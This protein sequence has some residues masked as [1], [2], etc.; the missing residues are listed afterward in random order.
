[1][2]K[3]ES[4]DAA[5]VARLCKVWDELIQT[6]ERLRSERGAAR[7]ERDQAFRERDQACQERDD[8]QQRVGSLQADLE[9]ATTRRLEAE[10]VSAGLTV[11]LAEVRRNLQ[12]ES[13]ELG[14]LSTVL[15]VVYGDLQVVRSEG[16]SLLM[17]HA[18]EI[19]AYVR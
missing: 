12:A 6:T 2:E 16:T 13:D 15:G 11:D 8:T 9:S 4:L 19:M 7:E 5:V 17:A 18:I 1:M 10:S 14:I 3:R